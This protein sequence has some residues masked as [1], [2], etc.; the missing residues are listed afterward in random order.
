MWEK[1]VIC[2][3]ENCNILQFLYNEFQPFDYI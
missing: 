1:N 2:Q 3:D